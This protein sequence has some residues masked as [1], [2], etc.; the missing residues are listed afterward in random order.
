MKENKRETF[1]C[2]HCG[3]EVRIKSGYPGRTAFVCKGCFNTVHCPDTK[4]H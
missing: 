2:P 1:S 4:T 3:E